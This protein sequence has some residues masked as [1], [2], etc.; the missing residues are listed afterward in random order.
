MDET[1]VAKGHTYITL[2]VD[3]EQQRTVHISDGKDHQTVVD[4]VEVLEAHQGHPDNIEQVSC[5]LS[6]AFIKGVRKSLPRA[7]IT[8]DKFHIMKIIN[9]AVDQVRREEAKTNPLLKGARYAV[10]KNDGNLTAKQKATKE[11]LCL[12]TLNLKTVRAMRL[13][14]TFQQLYTAPTALAFEKHLT[15]WYCWATHCRLKPMIRVAKT[16]K[17]HWQGVLQWKISQINNGILEGLN[18]VLQ[19]AK[20]KARGYKAA[21]FKTIAYL[22]TGKLDFSKINEFC[23]P[24]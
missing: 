14:E 3:I 18:S 22:L 24:T 12:S 6:P 4:C 13:R 8:F 7:D 17:R 5:D 23:L 9:A 16:I 10:L 15:H 11:A 19:A 21:H 20:R 1:S 2:F